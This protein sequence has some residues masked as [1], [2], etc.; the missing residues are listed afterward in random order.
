MLGRLLT[1]EK[2]LREHTEH[3]KTLQKELGSQR[4]LEK[5][6]RAS[7]AHLRQQLESCQVLFSLP[8]TD[9]AAV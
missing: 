7:A 1:A 6:L 2:S 3:Q 8:L 5:T 4:A 9:G